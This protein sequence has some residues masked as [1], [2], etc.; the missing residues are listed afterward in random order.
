MKHAP[1]DYALVIGINDYPNWNDGAKSLNGAV[2]DA[3]A[4]RDWLIADDGGG[5]IEEHVKLIVSSENPAAPR[6]YAI[7]DAFRDIRIRSKVSGRRRRFYFYFSGHGHIKAGSWRQ[8]SLCLPNWSPEDAGAALHL[9]SYLTTAVGCLNFSEAIFILDCCRVRAIAPVGQQSELEC[10]NP[11]EK[12]CHHAVLYGS[13]QYEPTFEGEVDEEIRGYFTAALVKVLREGTIELGDLLD[14]L[15]DIVPELARPKEQTVRADRTN[16]KIYLGPPDRIPPRAEHGD[17]ASKIAVTIAVKSSLTGLNR[18]GDA[19]PPQ[20]GH[21]TIL[22]GDAVVERGS[23][24]LRASLAS[25]VY[26]VRVDHGEASSTTDLQVDREPIDL[27]IELPRRSSATLLSGTIGKREF[28]TD[29]VVAASRWEAKKGEQAAFISLRAKTPGGDIGLAGQLSLRRSDEYIPIYEPTSLHRLEPGMTEL[30]YDGPDGAYWRLPIPI[31]EGWDTQIFIIVDEGRPLLATSS[32]SMRPAGEGFDPSD[33]LI[34][35]YERGIADLVTGGPGLDKHT[36]DQLLWGKYRNPLFGLLGAH[37]LIRKL[38]RG[39]QRHPADLERLAIVTSNLAKLFGKNMP[40]IVALRVWAQLLTG[41]EP[42]IDL[43]HE[44]PLFS[45]GFQ[46]FVETSAVS[47]WTDF[48]YVDDVALGLDAN[49]P[50]TLWES[51]GS[52]I[53]LSLSYHYPTSVATLEAEGA[54]ADRFA[55]LS[56]YLEDRGFQVETGLEDDKIRLTAM[57]TGDE[58]SGELNKAYSLLR[59]PDWIV[60]YMREADRL[61]AGETLDLA[62]LVRRTGLPAGVLV[63]AKAIADFG[64]IDRGFD[65]LVGEM[66]AYDDDLFGTDGAAAEATW[67]AEPESAVRS[68]N[69]EDDGEVSEGMA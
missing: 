54:N 57:R 9:D 40:D 16:K 47:G 45:V 48:T 53:D 32:I 35:A 33:A 41:K 3:E 58:Q 17:P 56:R 29:P 12:D 51:H 65:A 52:F 42:T 4:F 27:E 15:A 2:P 30:R 66:P 37:F 6:Q 46:A 8:Q 44:L 67:T 28:L 63:A 19:R 38:R 10:G 61:K 31:A 21:I 13:D 50:W 20:P 14:R 60:D 25:G 1:D 23:G 24:R 43:P 36:L 55:L 39:G 18:A 7:D 59:I 49:S 34:D 69:A 68:R 26:R 5:L 11:N 62:K 64:T 22:K